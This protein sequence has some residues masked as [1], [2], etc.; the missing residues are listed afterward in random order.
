MKIAVGESR[1][2]DPG[3]DPHLVLTCRSSVGTSGSVLE[4]SMERAAQQA[5]NV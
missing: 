5:L 4:C 3:A 1:S 2:A